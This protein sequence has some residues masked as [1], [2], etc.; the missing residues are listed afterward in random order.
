MILR[1]GYLQRDRDA[2]YGKKV[3]RRIRSLGVQEVVS[4]PRSPWKN[5]YVE[6]VI[7]SIRRDCLDHTI[8][9]NERHLR[10]ILREYIE[11]YHTC[12]TH[13]SLNKDPPETRIVEPPKLGN[14][15]AL[16]RIGGLNHRY[17]RIA[18]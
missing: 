4:A 13:L 14:V 7:G 16:P 2:I 8:V 9:L 10:R 15:V 5:P 18:A 12:R 3:W 1:H 17:S 11:Y 6:R